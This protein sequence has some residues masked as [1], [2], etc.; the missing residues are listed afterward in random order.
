MEEFH[1]LQFL[2]VMLAG[3]I[4][5]LVQ[6]FTEATRTSRAPASKVIVVLL[7]PPQAVLQYTV[8]VTLSPE[9]LVA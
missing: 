4:A 7:E 3:L 9:S 2:P 1:Y 8:T 6:S 5:H